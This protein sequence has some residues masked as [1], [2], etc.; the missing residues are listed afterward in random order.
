MSTSARASGSLTVGTLSAEPGSKARGPVLADL[1]AITMNIPVTLI[2]GARRGPRIVITAGMHGGEFTGVDAATRLSELLKPDEVS[3]Q[4]I[5]CPVANPPA[6]YDGRL[7]VS[8]LDGVNINRVFPGDAEGGPTERLA[9]WLFA[10]LVGG[11]DA[12]IDLHSG[13]IDETLHDFI[14]YRLTGE[15]GLDEKTRHMAHALGIRDVV[16]GLNAEGG[17]SHAAAARHGIPA[18]LVETGD[19]GERDPAAADRLVDALCGLLG[20]LRVLDRASREPLPV[21][22]WVWAGAITAE[23]TGLWYS[24]VAAGDDVTTGQVIGRITDPATGR[25]HQVVASATGRVFYG[26]HG[27][28]VAPGAELAAIAAPRD[29]GR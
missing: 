18:L 11:A 9:A 16:L 27:L 2:N 1:G 23:T 19:R 22:E 15:P 17:N 4:V 21:R 26:M 5:V 20:E 8:P 28:T 14:G 6:V 12:Y 7:G 29:P 10:G 3:G 24:D 25:E 13:G